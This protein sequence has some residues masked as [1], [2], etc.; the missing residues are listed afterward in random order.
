MRSRYAA[1]A[2]GDTE[3]LW[4]TLHPD[5]DDRTRAREGWERELRKGLKKLRYRRLR[6]LDSAPPDE[7]GVARVLFHVA[8]SQKVG[9]T[10][11]DRSFAELSLFAHDGEGWRYLVGETRPGVDP[12]GLAIAAWDR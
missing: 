5:H 1:F 12:S 7:D 10:S 11:R 4:R 2:L 3:Y 6:I 9:G 8:M